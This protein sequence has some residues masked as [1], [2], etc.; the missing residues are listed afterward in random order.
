MKVLVVD[1]HAAVS[2]FLARVARQEGHD[3]YEAPDAA[4]GLDL[5][6]KERPDV[7]FS[8]YMMP[9][10]TGLELL[11][12]IRHEAP[13]T[14]FVLMTG[15]GT[16]D[17]AAKALRFGASNY[18]NKP[19]ELLELRRML[20][21]FDAIVT[22]RSQQ[23][24]VLDLLVH[25]SLSMEFGNEIDR[26]TSIAEYLVAQC[27]Q[28]FNADERFGLRIGLQELIGNAMEHGNLAITRAEKTAAIATGPA[29]LQKLRQQR[30]ADPTLAARRVR[31]TM[32]MTRDSVQWTIRDDGQGFDWRKL[33]PAEIGS[34]AARQGRGIALARVHFNTIAYL[35]KGNSVCVTRQF[36]PTPKG[37][38]PR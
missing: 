31:V 11:A 21:R 19:V 8:D 23:N 33:G 38:L 4:T 17:L 13:Q 35:E 26:V 10:Q 30:L 29:G 20:K 37:D 9:G 7:V 22:E 12:Q 32:E 15:H 16:E 34:E 27:G 25:F 14:F 3:V 24:E 18:L 2:R 1:D 36:P 28:R 6:L 5:V